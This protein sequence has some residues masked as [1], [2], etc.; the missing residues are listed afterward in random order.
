MPDS[1]LSLPDAVSPSDD[2]G[3]LPVVSDEELLTLYSRDER[4]RGLLASTIDQRRSRLRRF[5]LENEGGFRAATRDSIDEWLDERPITSKTR[6]I[7][8]SHLHCF[9]VWAIEMGYLRKDPTIGIVRPRLR[10][11]LP[12]PISD[13][14]LQTALDAATVKMRVWLLLGAYEG[15]RCQEIAGLARHDVIESDML[16]RVVHGKG[17]AER[18]MPLHPE[19]LEALRE[20][21]LPA[22][23]AIFRAPMGGIYAP[24]DVSHGINNFL[25]DLGIHSTAHSLRHWFGTHLYRESHDLRLVQEMLGHQSP[26]TTAI[27]TAFDRR[28]ATDAVRALKL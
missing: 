21:G 17:D 4:R 13:E 25:R 20:Y 27:Y 2:S 6:Y 5:L 8:L 24:H 18:I 11:R 10:R 28:A 16:I 1:N 3:G 15:F 23:G 14:D 26:T 19:V 7:W 12:R 9:Y 22:Q